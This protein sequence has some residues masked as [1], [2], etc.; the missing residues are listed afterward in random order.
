MA[1]RSP[2]FGDC[3]LRRYHSLQSVAGGIRIPSPQRHYAK[4]EPGIGVVGCDRERAAIALD[5]FR[6]ALLM[7]EQVAEVAV[8]VRAVRRCTQRTSQVLLRF[9]VLALRSQH[10]ADQLQYLRLIRRPRHQH[11]QNPQRCGVA[12]GARQLQSPAQFG[13]VVHRFRSRTI[14]GR[15]F[16]PLAQLQSRRS[17]RALPALC[18]VVA[19]RANQLAGI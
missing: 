12:A 5:G 1:Q 2:R 18:V 10:H 11:F 16:A 13:F 19:W 17:V 6:V 8:D 3:R 4:V 9:G 14:D 7:R 15:S